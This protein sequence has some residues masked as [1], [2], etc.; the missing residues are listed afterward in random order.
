LEFDVLVRSVRDYAI[1][2]LDRDG[3]VVTWNEG[4]ERFK[5]YTADEII[6]HHVSLFYPPKDQLEGKPARL[7][8][9]AAAEG[10]VEDEGWR[11]RKDG[12]RFWADVVI[13]AIHDK[14]GTLL[15][16]CKV[17][18]DLT[19]RRE[20]E[21]RR[22]LMAAV[23]DNL[24]GGIAILD[25]KLRFRAVNAAYCEPFGMVP[26]DFVGR[27]L[28][29]VF[30]GAEAQLDGR[31]SRVTEQ[32]ETVTIYGYGYRNGDH[33]SFWDVTYAPVKDADGATSGVVIMCFDVTPRV[34][35]EREMAEQRQLNERI[36][37]KAPAGIAFLDA[38]LVYRRVNFAY[39]DLLGMRV[40][41]ILDKSIWE[42]FPGATAQF[43]HL[44]RQ[45]QATGEPYSTT[46]FSF[47]FSHQGKE[48]Q[49]YWDF[50]YQ[51]I[52]DGHG[53]TGILILEVEVSDR[54]ENGRLQQ[55]QIARLQELD[56]MKDEFLS[57]ISH[58]LRTPL[59]F[60]MGFAS[61]LEDEVQ[62]PL[63]D[64][65]H[66]AIAKIL[67]GAD[68]M[69]VLVDDLLDFAKIQSGQLDLLVTAT[70]YTPLVEEVLGLMAPL[71]ERKGVALTNHVSADLAPAID[72]ARVAQILTN[73][74]GN[75]IKFT[76]AGGQVDVRARVD[77]GQLLTEV[78]DTGLG[79]EPAERGKLFQ[80]FRQLDMS[81]TREAGGTGL[82]LAISKALVEAH[83][84][85]IGV[86]SQPGVGSTFW[87]RLPF[88]GV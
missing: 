7:L 48:V 30:P 85:T 87:F 32:G 69:L 52:T 47:R 8:G 33:E 12:T 34:A 15:G 67:N 49:T 70:P 35:L 57:V 54:Q 21:E 59:N 82:G 4:A 79:I 27:R 83:G 86:E 20:A 71:A 13:T 63:N 22:G 1:F 41:E 74:V 42:V 51:P 10:R 66:E 88:A 31:I 55:E 61:T 23:F 11:I 14:D 19:E 44:M 60:I 72:G 46:N 81:H 76:A 58:E 80:R 43:E 25:L 64:R 24:P 6:G 26:A 53:G 68:R 39:A 62:G 65:Q 73:L 16:F 18:R 28:F 9:I 36:V 78:R 5:G 29:D 75:A 56:R 2:L 84:G 77:G 3:R 50:T 45:V 37:D 38:G 17:T 40:D